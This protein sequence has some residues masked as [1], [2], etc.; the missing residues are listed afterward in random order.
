MPKS[1]EAARPGRPKS[2]HKGQAVLYA[3]GELFLSNGYQRTSMDAVA[4]RAGVSKQTV[5]SHF[6]NKEELF[7]ACIRGKVEGY[8]FGETSPDAAADLREALLAIARQFVDLMFDPDVIAMHRLVLAEAA[9]QPRIAQLFFDS[10]PQRTRAAVCAFLQRQVD[11]GRLRIPPERLPYAAVQLLSAAFGLYQMPLW[12]GLSTAAGADE[13]DAH[14]ARVVDD[15][16]A[17]YQPKD[18]A[19]AT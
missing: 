16:L 4:Q 10:G 9:K 5:Y 7:T 13:I 19:G 15:F 18:D 6:A 8:G 17:L 1:G 12:L 14:L 3:A 2:E 11:A